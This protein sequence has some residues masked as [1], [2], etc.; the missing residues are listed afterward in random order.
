M[1]CVDFSAVVD[2]YIDR[3][4]SPAQAA[5][6]DAHITNCEACRTIVDDR[7]ALGRL[8]GA[9]T[10]HEAPAR[11]RAAI[12]ARTKPRFG[13]PRLLLPFAA[14]VAAVIALGGA[15]V[16][17][18]EIQQSRAGAM[19]ARDAEDAVDAHVRALQSG[20]LYD[21]RSSDQHTVKP[22]F[23]GKIDF[24]PPVADLS[25]AGFPLAGGRVDLLDGQPEAALVYTRRL[26]PIDAFIRPASTPDRRVDARTIRGFQVR[27]WTARAMSFWV[28][29]DLDGAELDDFVTE[30]RRVLG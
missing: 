22:W 21:V 17:V 30:L 3:E 7:R 18:R 20:R 25:G 5:D 4:L 10:Y 19:L 13:V 9:M 6:A 28:V 26:H 29:S 2:A 16:G 23:L 24:A 1:T 11:M 14:S 12:V 15:A 27:H 8:L